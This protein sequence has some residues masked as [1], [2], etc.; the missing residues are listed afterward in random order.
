M[1]DRADIEDVQVT[2]DAFTMAVGSTKATPDDFLAKAPQG[3]LLMPVLIEALA[4]AAEDDGALPRF[5]IRAFYENHVNEAARGSA[6]DPPLRYD[7]FTAMTL[8]EAFTWLQSKGYLAHRGN[9]DSYDYWLA[10]PTG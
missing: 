6:D 2:D 3:F 5:D 9:G 4:A 1:F 10:T 8:M 7:A